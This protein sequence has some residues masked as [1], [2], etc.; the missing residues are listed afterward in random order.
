M[1]CED[2][3]SLHMFSLRKLGNFYHTLPH[4]R[5]LS[6]KTQQLETVLSLSYR[7]E[8]SKIYLLFR[9]H[10]VCS[11]YATQMMVEK[12]SGLIINVSSFG[13]IRYLFNVAYGIGKCAV[14]I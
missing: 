9:N 7:V 8:F 12:K 1:Y 11:V 4:Q 14:S 6:L 5:I 2:L 10:Y 3:N 13:G